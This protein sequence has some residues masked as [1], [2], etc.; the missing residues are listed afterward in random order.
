MS[1]ELEELQGQQEPLLSEQQRYQSNDR[2]P[3]TLEPGDVDGTSPATGAQSPH[4]ES[5]L[6]RCNWVTFESSEDVRIIPTRCQSYEDV[7][8]PALP[9]GSEN[10]EFERVRRSSMSEPPP[11]YD[12]VFPDGPTSMLAGQLP[13]Y[14]AVVS[15]GH[16]RQPSRKQHRPRDSVVVDLPQPPRKTYRPHDS[17]PVVYHQPPRMPHRQRDVALVA[18][19]QPR[20]I[21]I[22]ICA[23]DDVQVSVEEQSGCPECTVHNWGL[24]LQCCVKGL[25]E[26]IPCLIIGSCL[27]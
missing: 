14:D 19:H 17:V 16:F 21:P 10:L 18:H 25:C 22:N 13:T 23:N 5:C 27:R 4:N 11:S 15:R 6:L 7:S 8:G 24:C 20:H 26:F 2:E 12:E 1:V 9:D 3:Q